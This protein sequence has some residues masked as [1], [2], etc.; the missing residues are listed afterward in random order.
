MGLIKGTIPRGHHHFPYDC[1]FSSLK[2]VLQL[3]GCFFQIDLNGMC[4]SV[5]V[6]IKMLIY[7]LG[8]ILCVYKYHKVL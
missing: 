8:D 5:E 7:L 2:V 6:L 4:L 1:L 3:N